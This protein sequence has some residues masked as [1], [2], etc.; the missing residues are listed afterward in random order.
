MR[1]LLHPLNTILILAVFVAA[2]QA[3]TLVITS[4]SP[5][6]AAT[7][8]Y[9][10]ALSLTA[11]ASIRQVDFAFE[12][13]TD[14]SIA[15]FRSNTQ[16]V[17]SGSTI[18][19]SY[20]PQRLI[21]SLTPVAASSFSFTLTNMYNPAS[22]RPYQVT[23]TLTTTTGS[24]SSYTGSL[25]VTQVANTTFPIAGY[26]L[27]VGATSTAA[28]LFLAPQNAQKFNNYFL[29]ITYDSSLISL[30]LGTSTLY[31]IVSSSVGTIVLGS[32]TST[33]NLLIIDKV[34][35]VNPRAAITSTINCLFY[36]VSSSISYNVEAFFASNT[37]TAEVYT[38]LTTSS[39]FQYGLLGSLSIISSC[40]YSQVSNGSTSAYTVLTYNSSQLSTGSSSNCQSTSSTTCR[41]NLGNNYTLTSILPSIDNYSSSTI[42]VTSY[43]FFNGA[44]Y[45][46]C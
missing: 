10:I 14:S 28:S 45:P 33:P 16:L 42:T 8:N 2:L 12:P 7:A 40:P 11:Q 9:T 23:V 27:N 21:C 17:Y 26:S 34:T 6:A 44:F 30:S 36:I 22:T 38:T 41:H 19:P 43:T 37:L 1:S 46:L 24:T 3:A 18:Q 29:R 4:S 31:S 13:W 25:T 35:I 15:P 20:F 32:F 5:L 39:T